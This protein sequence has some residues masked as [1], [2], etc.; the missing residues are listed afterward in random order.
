MQKTAAGRDKPMDLP[1]YDT[2]QRILQAAISVFADKGY[3]R[4]T[5]KEIADEARVNIAAINYHFGNKRNLYSMLVDQ[6]TAFANNAFAHR[7]EADAGLPRLEVHTQ[8]D[9]ENAAMHITRFSL[10]AI[11]TEKQCPGNL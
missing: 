1:L 7:R 5:V 11:A 4:G 8:E 3:K 2:K 6:W 10:N 9:V